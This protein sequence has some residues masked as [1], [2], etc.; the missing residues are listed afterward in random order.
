MRLSRFLFACALL[1]LSGFS[2]A[3]DHDDVHA[4]VMRYCELEGNL[5]AQE[6]M[7]ASDRVMITPAMRQTNQ[8]L[9]M[10][11]QK[12]N[13]ELNAK[14]DPGLE[15]MVR[16]E[17]PLVRVYGD[18]AVAS[19][20]RYWNWLWSTE[21]LSENEPPVTTNRDVTSLVL[22]KQGGEWKI[23]HTHISPFHPSN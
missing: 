15:V 14:R 11:L 23:V 7:I 8:A 2:Y 12:R 17:D 6:K 21:F 4:F 18:T 5:E 13:R 9:N 16:C 19:V 22:R 3:D 10:K 1:A 20:Y